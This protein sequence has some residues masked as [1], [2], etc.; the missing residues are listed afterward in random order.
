MGGLIILQMQ[1][2]SEREVESLSE[3]LDYMKA[4]P[5]MIFQKEEE[6]ICSFVYTLYLQKRL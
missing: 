4:H 1:C 3:P 2:K 6:Y 5:D